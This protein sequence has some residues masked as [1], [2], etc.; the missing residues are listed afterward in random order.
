MQI[1]VA[2]CTY[3]GE[4]HLSAQLESIAA[5]T[6]PADELVV[7]DD[8]STDATGQI[9][10]DFAA[11]AALPVNFSINRENLGS[12]RNFARAIELCQGDVIVLADQDDVWKPH[13]LEQLA[14]LLTDECIGMAFSN[15]DVVGPELQPLGYSL[16]DGLPDGD[17]VLRAVD[18]QRLF[19]RLLRGN[20]VTGATM[21]FRARYKDLVLPIPPS[22][23]HDEWIALLISAVAPYRAT[24]ERL[25]SYRQ[26]STQ[27]IG[28]RRFSLRDVAAQALRGTLKRL[29]LDALA[30]GLDSSAGR[31]ETAPAFAAA[32]E[33]IADLRAKAAHFRAR[34]RSRG[35]LAGRVPGIARELCAGR[36]HRYSLGWLTVARD[37]IAV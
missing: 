16:W 2:L 7:C 26:H 35:G 9:V 21:A 31:L 17:Q 33:R 19:E 11:R 30:H 6:R 8:R 14:A 15:A 27:Q 18:E 3:N 22:W 20:V 23:V 25:I 28:A 34:S 5:Q 32:R 36:Y 29:D 24:A 13:K 37:L 10:Q 12:T 4:R 1:S